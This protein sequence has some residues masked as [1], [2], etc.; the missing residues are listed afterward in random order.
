MFDLSP[1]HINIRR[2]LANRSKAL[3]RELGNPLEPLSDNKRSFKE[4]YTKSTWIKMFSPANTKLNT[5][6]A[7]IFAGEVIGEA[8]NLE[9]FNGF[10]QVYT[11]QKAGGMFD[12]VADQKGYS[13]D[14][15][16]PIAGINSITCEYG[17]GV[18]AL[19]QATINWTCWTFEDLERLT[20][21]FMA[22]GKG[23]LLE[24]GYG[25][26]AD[27]SGNI[28]DLETVS[29]EDMRNGKAYNKINELVIQ[30]G[31]RYDGIA[32]IISNYEY[33]VRDDGGFDVTTNIVS[34]G[35]NIFNTQLDQS[36]APM[37]VSKDGKEEVEAWPTLGEFVC[38]LEEELYTLAT[39]NSSFGDF[40][41]TLPPSN[42]DDFSE[43][44]EK[45]TR[46]SKLPPG[47]LVY[48]TDGWFTLGREAGPYV[49][50]GFLEDNILNK[51]VG[52]FSKDDGRITSQI[53]SIQPKGLDQMPDG[54][55]GKIEDTEWESVKINNH[56]L[57]FTP[58]ADRWILPGQF[59]AEV[60][61]K[62]GLTA[63][64]ENFMMEL[65]ALANNES[66]FEPFDVDG[67]RSKG[68]VRNI[69]LSFRIIKDA[70]EDARTLEEGMS[71]LFDQINQD[72][73]GFWNYRLVTDTFL[74]GNVKVS[75]EK[76]VLKEASHYLTQ[77][78]DSP[79]PN[80]DNEMFIFDTWGEGSIVIS[81]ELSLKLPSSFAVTAM[82]AS[83]SPP[84]AGE[85]EGD[86][87]AQAVGEMTNSDA[88]DVS[89]PNIIRPSRISTPAFGT[90]N[91]YVLKGSG[92]V[93]PPLFG[94][95]K[96]I[97]FDSIGM[98]QI[99]ETYKEKLK[100]EKDLK[101]KKDDLNKATI[102]KQTR[103]A[104][105]ITNFFEV[106]NKSKNG[107][108]GTEE[109]NF[110]DQ[111]GNMRQKFPDT[112]HHTVM[113]NVLSG[114]QQFAMETA[115]GGEEKFIKGAKREDIE[116]KKS[117]TGLAPIELSIKIDGVGGIFPGNVWHTNYIQKRYR[118]YG[119]WQTMEVTQE[120]SPSGWTTDL[121][122]QI[123]VSADLLYGDEKITEVNETIVESNDGETIEELQEQYKEERQE[124]PLDYTDREEARI[125][126][127]NDAFRLARKE[128]G[129]NAK[130][131]Y[132]GKAYV[133]RYAEEGYDGTEKISE[134]D[135]PF[136]GG[137]N[138]NS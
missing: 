97:P 108:R 110:Y 29:D 125:G 137:G 52:R 124:N 50:W 88:I 92:E 80:P 9:P 18:K 60:L 28:Q 134:D 95:D 99:M 31:G 81:Q 63:G 104:N 6:G 23:V 43:P 62:E 101:K 98:E 120:V 41:K 96:G 75:D 46:G 68:Y 58:S 10:G 131:Y 114:N 15:L 8:G 127:F 7:R 113:L 20:P 71:N 30:A 55:D 135:L 26:I 33:N 49:T 109:L 89:Q 79:N 94:D 128:L 84:K 56:P 22:H 130:F 64:A 85:T 47:V 118:D 5:V 115:E 1:I 59:P 126:G 17:S 121:K 16:R 119:V 116:T 54:F 2:T 100:N 82:Y 4:T 87:D 40:T 42:K 61:K 111:D 73:G 83:T 39:E 91:P 12:P 138:R 38:I 90:Q 66:Y 51:W 105:T 48:A 102:L 107:K 32:G 24:W 129:P 77:W 34:R 67:T 78:N 57:L 112:Y 93:A 14:L 11:P 136:Y 69:L 36:D 25:T 70:F 3:K 53:R 19:R 65:A 35:V 13:Q 45:W 117:T 103:E 21:H 86:K 72:V 133:T 132:N 74:S 76:E 37:A 106:A 44:G 122:G 123:R 27:A